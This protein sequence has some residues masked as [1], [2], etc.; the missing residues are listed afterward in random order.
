MKRNGPLPVMSVTCLNGSVIA[1]RS[2][3]IGQM[4]P[5]V[6]ASASG[7]SGNGR[8]RRNTM[9][10]SSG[11]DTSAVAAISADPNASRTA[12]RRTLATQSRASTGVPSWNRSPSRSVSRHSNPSAST[13]CPATIC[14]RATKD[15]SCP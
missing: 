2:G 12:Q 3:M 15:S 1:S 14:G 6:L 7:S 9:L 10:R 5:A 11:A 4:F 8:I 13:T